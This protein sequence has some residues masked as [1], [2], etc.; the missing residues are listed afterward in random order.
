MTE[1][2]RSLAIIK[3]NRTFAVDFS[4][5]HYPMKQ[6]ISFRMRQNIA[7]TLFNKRNYAYA[8][9]YQLPAPQ[10]RITL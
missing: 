7:Q 5:K 1:S 4:F 10:Q 2:G 3:K 6:I 9:K 8:S